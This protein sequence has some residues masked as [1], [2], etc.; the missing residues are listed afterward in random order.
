MFEINPTKCF[1]VE[2]NI[3]LLLLS[4]VYYFRDWRCSSTKSLHSSSVKRQS[5]IG[6]VGLSIG[7]MSSLAPPQQSAASASA[8]AAASASNTTTHDL[9]SNRKMS[10]RHKG[11]SP[12]VINVHSQ[13]AIA[14]SLKLFLKTMGG[15][16][17]KCGA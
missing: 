1:H 16:R 8:A 5:T 12:Q 3:S 9:T 7:S 13:V 17:D 4:F 10:A 2:I 14:P 6:S 15:H 11:L